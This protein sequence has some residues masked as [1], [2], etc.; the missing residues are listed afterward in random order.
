MSMSKPTA[1]GQIVREKDAQVPG[2]TLISFI[3]K[4]A[5]DFGLV[6]PKHITPERM[7]RLAL[8][9][10]RTNSSLAQTSLPSFASAIMACATLGLEPNTAAGFAYL[11]PRKNHGVLECTLQVGYKGLIELMYRSGYVSSVM[12]TPVFDGDFF[13]YE[14]GLSP[15]LIHRPL[16]EDDP[17]K[18]TH[19]YTIVRWKDGTDPIWDVLTRTQIDKRRDR[20]GYQ[21][22]R[23]RG[24]P[25]PWDTDYVAMALKTGVRAIARWTPQSSERIGV[26][27]AIA[28]EEAI[29]RGQAQAAITSLGDQAVTGMLSMGQYPQDDAVAAA[30]EQLPVSDTNGNA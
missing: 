26:H 28:Y 23:D 2:S 5:R 11:I 18:L 13:E 9:A 6:L 22:T 21:Q 10:V 24:R 3:E 19:V 14:K 8:S 4:H 15:K 16:G 27:Q 29:E 12:A 17:R 1:N 30:E 25:S 7:T 20:G